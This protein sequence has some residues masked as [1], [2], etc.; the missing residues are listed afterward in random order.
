MTIGSDEVEIRGTWSMVAGKATPDANTKRIEVLINEHLKEI[1]RD[2]AGW[3][4]LYVDPNDGRYWE[5]TYPQSDM[6]GG[7]PPMLKCLTDRRARDKYS[8]FL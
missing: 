4:V 2:A 1:G 8:R 5:L 3:D 6:H 7:G